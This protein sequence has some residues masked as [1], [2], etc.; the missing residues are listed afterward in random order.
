MLS[1]PAAAPAEKVV[2][3]LS[4][5]FGSNDRAIRR[6]LLEAI[7]G[8]AK[9]LSEELVEDK[10]FPAIATGASGGYTFSF[11]ILRF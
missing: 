1:P 11:V 2:P 7:D 10:I 5:L 9:Y 8:F 4:R 3:S 6:S